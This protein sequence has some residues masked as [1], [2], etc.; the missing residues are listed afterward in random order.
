M[1]CETISQFWAEFVDNAR[2]DQESLEFRPQR[3]QS[4][5]SEEV[6]NVAP[7]SAEGVECLAGGCRPADRKC[8]QPQSGR[9]TLGS[10]HDRLDGL[11]IQAAEH[12]TG[13][14]DRERKILR[15]DLG[16]IAV[17]A[18]SADWQRRVHSRCHHD[19]QVRR[20][21]RH[22]P[23]ERFEDLFV[24]DLVQIVQDKGQRAA[25]TLDDRNDLVGS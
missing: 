18:K 24:A 16:E 25:S 13:L 5:R 21:V 23:G 1:L 14:V 10:C 11:E 15:S 17:R 7:V 19:S 2:C 6:S 4:L 3:T 12:R 20:Q 9:P 8:E 22:D